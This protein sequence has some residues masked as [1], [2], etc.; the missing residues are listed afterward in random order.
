M[1]KKDNFY[2]IVRIILLLFTVVS[3][4]KELIVKDYYGLSMCVLTLGLFTLP[5]GISKVF[6]ITFPE[7][8]KTAIFFYI[9]TSQVLGEAYKFYVTFSFW[10]YFVHIFS[11]FYL[12]AV[13]FNLV[14]LFNKK[15]IN[16]NKVFVALFAFSF[17]ILVGVLWEVFEYSMDKLFLKDMQKDSVVDRLSS[18]YL[19]DNK[20]II[21][22][23]DHTILYDKDG[24]EI[25]YM[26][27]YL[28]IGLEDTMDDFLAD[29][30]GSF[31]FSTFVY[32]YIKDK[33]KYPLV[34]YFMIEK[35]T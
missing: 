8:F 12:A 4:I 24:K 29:M 3:I 11:S 28:D 18:N 7:Q 15:V 23:I 20:V 19:E 31:I 5:N 9:F 33:K 32:L 14:R 35:T 2:K 10:D 30:I 34:G 26:D 27:G 21:K 17:A 13:G 1:K 25:Y 6:K 16:M 22:D